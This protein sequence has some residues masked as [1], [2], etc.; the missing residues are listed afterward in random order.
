MIYNK[1]KVGERLKE[2]VGDK[3]E[4]WFEGLE[5]HLKKE[6]DQELDRRILIEEGS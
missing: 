6:L 1:D 2:E 3:P 5:K 4:K